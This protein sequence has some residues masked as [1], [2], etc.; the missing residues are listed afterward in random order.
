MPWRDIDAEQ[1]SYC[2]YY[3]IGGWLLCFYIIA[4]I[5]FLSSIGD[6]FDPD[7]RILAV[8]GGNQGVAQALS[9]LSLAFQLPFL[10]LVPLRH[11]LMPFIDIACTWLNAVI[12]LPFVMSLD[13]TM[14]A[15]PFLATAIPVAIVLTSALW[16]WYLL[17][18]TSKNSRFDRG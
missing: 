14:G 4:G 1:A 9:I 16:T 12:F 8:F 3:G 11:R 10:I 5:G 17:Q 13:I 2:E 6:A 18:G 7:A 15:P